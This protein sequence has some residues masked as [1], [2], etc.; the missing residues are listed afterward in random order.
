MRLDGN[1]RSN[2][3]NKESSQQHPINARK[4]CPLP[5]AIDAIEPISLLFNESYFACRPVDPIHWV[6]DEKAHCVEHVGVADFARVF[7]VDGVYACHGGD[8][9]VRLWAVL[10][11][12]LDQQVRVVVPVDTAAFGFL[13]IKV[14]RAV[15]VLLA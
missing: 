9:A 14:K 2:G 3:I 6:R 7:A 5:Y 8:C 11:V 1:I 10:V 4:H 12:L 15:L 13:A